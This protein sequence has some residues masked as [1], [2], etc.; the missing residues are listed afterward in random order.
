MANADRDV[1]AITQLVNL[2][3][4]AVDSQQWQLFDSIFTADVG[5]DH[6]HSFCHGGWRLVRKAAV[7]SPLWEG[8][9][10]YDDTLVRT[11]DGWRIPPNV[12]HY[13]VDR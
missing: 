6:A 5:G 9:G 7:G 13:L 2:Y 11:A 12:P 3:G 4:L 1:V 8:T 10:W